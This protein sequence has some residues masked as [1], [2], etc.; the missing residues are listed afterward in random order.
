MQ[1]ALAGGTVGMPRMPDT[2]RCAI[3]RSSALS[4][5]CE[6]PVRAEA[7]LLGSILHQLQAAGTSVSCHMCRTWTIAC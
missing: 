6:H 2:S 1:G 5:Q 3:R 4:V 7:S